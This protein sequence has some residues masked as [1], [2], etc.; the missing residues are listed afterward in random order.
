MRSGAWRTW[1]RVHGPALIPG[2]IAV[3]L[4]LVWAADN[5][6]YD[7][8]TWYLGALLLLGVL[9][10]VL[11]WPRERPLAVTRTS[12]LA[13]GLFA[14]YVA[15]SYLSISWAQSPGDALQGSNRAF[16]YL[17]VFALLSVLPWTPHAAVLA[18]LTFAITIAVIA[19]VLL[20]RLASADN[21]GQIVVQ[22]RFLAPTGYY[23][24]SVAL[25][26]IGGLTSTVLSV[27]R[28]LP[29]PLRGFLLAG[30]AAC[31]QLAVVGQSRGWLFTLPLVLIATWAVVTDRLRVT[32]AAV[33]PLVATLVPVHRLLDIYRSHFGSVTLIHAAKSAG[34]ASLLLCALV[35]A[36]STLLA[37]AGVLVRP[38]ALK[39][40]TRRALGVVAAVAVLA[41]GAAGAAAATHGDPLAFIKRQWNGFS[42]PIVGRQTGSYF[43]SVGSGRY[44]FW[45][46]SIDAVAAHPL[47]GLGQ[48]NFADYYVKRRHTIE[49]PTWTHSLEMRLLA[50]TGIIGA[51][52]FAAFVIA[53]LAAALFARRRG[54]E[55]VRFAAGAT[56]LPLVV[57]LIHGSLD[58]FW[59]MPALSGAALGFLA[60][61]G[62]LGRS[63]SDDRA[64]VHVTPRR[65]TTH[66]L[67][68]VTGFLCLVA[69][70]VVLGFPYLS[71]REV[72]AATSIRERNST[73]ALTDLR[74]AAKLNPLTP[75]PDRLAGTIAL[76][77]G[78]LIVAQQRFREAIDR[79]PGG[80]FSWL[81]AG[82]AASALGNS[83]QARRDFQ[84]AASINNLQPAVTESLKRVDTTHPVTPKQALKMLVVVG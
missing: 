81:G 33:I 70:V 35:F 78:Q 69:G 27:R 32:A 6:G 54:P 13:L 7:P 24:A 50:H 11:L 19:I 21:L 3:A 34:H 38:R 45:R 73:Q 47:G 30:A 18:L 65:P 22:G 4:V 31:L 62:A 55:P 83:E 77:N 9:A 56:L 42:H 53:A 59:E 37:W 5:G 20:F 39:R 25:F 52:L 71:A 40:T 79:E 14:A 44:D 66:A 17:I 60:V 1:L 61:A 8:T 63:S 72:A 29:A 36:V 51:L 2:E 43:A 28:S 58:W 48:D 84:V 68:V 12:A 10:Q 15:W 67:A 76:E 16:L 75:L 80:W 23:N 41:A 46:A 26:T 49:E 74:T 64:L 82:L 57:W